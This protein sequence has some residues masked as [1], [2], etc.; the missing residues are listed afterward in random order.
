[1]VRSMDSVWAAVGIYMLTVVSLRGRVSSLELWR[2]GTLPV[3]MMVVLIAAV[4]VKGGLGVFLQ[5]LGQV[6]T[7]GAG[8]DIVLVAILW[9]VQLFHKA[10]RP[11]K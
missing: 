7:R 4:V 11:G 1:M 10:H 6:G 8:G 5:L 2:N 9:D 3:D